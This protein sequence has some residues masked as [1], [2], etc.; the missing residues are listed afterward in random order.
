[1]TPMLAC[2]KRLSCSFQHIKI[3]ESHRLG[4]DQ[5]LFQGKHIS[6]YGYTEYIRWQIRQD[7]VVARVHGRPLGRD[8]LIP[9]QV[10]GSELRS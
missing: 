1:M 8:P 2:L 5:A 9:S 4:Y 7:P 3:S 10:Y 6:G